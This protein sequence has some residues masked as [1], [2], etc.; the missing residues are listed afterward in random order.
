MNMRILVIR[1]SSLGDVVLAGG[2]VRALGQGVPG[3][4]IRFATKAAYAPVFDHFDPPVD[5]I[6]LAADQSFDDYV[7]R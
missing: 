5:I 3:C 1:F 4:H 7:Q 2:I 6:A